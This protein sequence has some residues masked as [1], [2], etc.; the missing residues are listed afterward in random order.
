MT[1]VYWTV[2]GL[3]SL[4]VLALTRSDFLFGAAT[5]IVVVSLVVWFL[6][7]PNAYL[8]AARP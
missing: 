1:L 2:L 6:H 4:A 7:R 3:V 8:P 5:G